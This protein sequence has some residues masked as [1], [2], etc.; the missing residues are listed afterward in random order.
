MI[1]FSERLVINLESMKLIQCKIFDWNIQKD[2][3]I[4]LFSFTLDTQGKLM[5]DYRN[6]IRWNLNSKQYVKGHLDE[7]GRPIT[8]RIARIYYVNFL[9]LNFAM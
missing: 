1:F 2:I 4:L 3:C 9:T 6:K 8:T 7:N 5:V